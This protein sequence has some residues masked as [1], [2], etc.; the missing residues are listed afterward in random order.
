MRRWLSWPERLG[1]E[2]IG[3]CPCEVYPSRIYP[4]G[5]A[6]VARER[7]QR[8]RPGRYS[9]SR[10]RTGTALRTLATLRTDINLFDDVDSYAGTAPHPPL[11]ISQLDWTRR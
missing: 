10:A 4:H 8:E 5:L 1:C 2:V 3:R 11:P 9:L 6:R 7:G